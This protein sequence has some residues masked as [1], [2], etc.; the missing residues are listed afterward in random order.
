M[1]G[2]GGDLTG[3]PLMQRFGVLGVIRASLAVYN[4]PEEMDQLIMG[5]E[6]FLSEGRRD[7]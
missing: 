3:Q 1:A 7:A 5:V 6:R 2:A 4:K